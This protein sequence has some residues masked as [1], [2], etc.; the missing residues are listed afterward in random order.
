MPWSR[1]QSIRGERVAPSRTPVAVVVG[2]GPIAVTFSDGA[3]AELVVAAI[4]VPVAGQDPV[5]DAARLATQHAAAVR[6]EAAAVAAATLGDATALGQLEARLLTALN[7]TLGGGGYL[8][9]VSV[10]LAKTTPERKDEAAPAR[11]R[12]EAREEAAPTLAQGRADLPARADTL[13]AP[14]RREGCTTCGSA[15]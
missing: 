5:A 3:A 7:A 1:P 2:G 15:R 14:C 12:R 6:A 10:A 4:V 8:E 11:E 13:W 9:E